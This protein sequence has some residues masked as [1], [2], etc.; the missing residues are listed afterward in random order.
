MTNIAQ[1]QKENWVEQST[2]TVN[3]TKISVLINKVYMTTETYC[4]QNINALSDSSFSLDR[5]LQKPWK[6]LLT[7]LV[8]VKTLYL[9]KNKQK[10]IVQLQ[11]A[12]IIT[13]FQEIHLYAA[14]FSSSR[15]KDKKMQPFQSTPCYI[16]TYLILG[17]LGEAVTFLI[18]HM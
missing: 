14:I 18:L 12:G 16:Y 1:Q 2:C 17:L 7:S 10:L 4:L 6:V 15:L 8:T 11:K 5:Q 9:L 13:F 3:G